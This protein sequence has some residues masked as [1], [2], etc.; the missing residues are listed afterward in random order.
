MYI[1]SGRYSGTIDMGLRI[2]SAAAKRDSVDSFHEMDGEFRFSG[3]I[4]DFAFV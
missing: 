1:F 4:S 3:Y 2:G